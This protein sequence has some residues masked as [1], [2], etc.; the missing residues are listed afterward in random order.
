MLERETKKS[1][2]FL[3]IDELKNPFNYRLKVLE[4]YQQKEVN[5]DLVETFNYLLGLDIK[6]NKQLR[7]N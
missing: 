3:K 6:G 5:V 7:N 1:K 4:D 2:T